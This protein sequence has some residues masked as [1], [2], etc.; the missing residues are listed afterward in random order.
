MDVKEA[1]ALYISRGWEVVPLS[2]G[3]KDCYAPN[4][5]KT[6]F[7]PDDF[8]DN[9]N[10]G[11]K[12][13]NGLVDI[14]LD[15]D[16][17]VA[18]ADTFLPETGAVYGRKSKPKSHR[19]YLSEIEKSAAFLDKT[20][21]LEIRINH[22]SMAPPSIHPNGE[23]VE[24]VANGSATEVDPAL[25]IR[26]VRLLAT[27]AII[28]RHYPGEGMRH[29][30]VM[31]I[32]GMLRQLGIEEED[33]LKCIVAGATLA[34][35]DEI[36]DDRVLIIRKTYSKSEDEPL[37][38]AKTLIEIVED[39]K[40]IVSALKKVWGVGEGKDSRGFRT[41]K[42]GQVI[43]NSLGN[44]LHAFKKLELSC[45]ED[46]F[47]HKIMV[48]DQPFSDAILDRILVDME[49]RFNL[50]A[51]ET[52][53]QRV[54]EDLA[55]RTPRHPVKEYLA[56]LTWDKK[57]RIDKWL[58]TYGGAD[59]TD[60]VRAICPIV[61][62]AAV[63]RIRKPGCKFD[64]MLIL[65]SEQ[66]WNK[67]TALRALCPREEWFT[68]DVSLGL[69]AKETIEQTGGC[70]IIE[71]S[72]LKG[73]KGRGQDR[74]KTFLSRQKDGPVRLA[75][76]K[77]PI[78]VPRQFIIIGTTNTKSG[79]LK[80]MTG[81]RRYWPVLVES[82]NIDKLKRDRDQL[83]AEAAAREAGGESIRLNR[84]LYSEA[85]MEQ[86]ARRGEDPWEEILYAK[87]KDENEVSY[88]QAYDLLSI[89]TERLSRDIQE[90]LHHVMQKLGF[91][92]NRTM[93]RDKKSVKGWR[94]EG[95]E[96]LLPA[97]V[98]KESK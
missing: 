31:P 55:R 96:P 13:I 72:E 1:A 90:R 84:N 38:A 53:T 7:K 45:Y 34:K 68:E 18:L 6:N 74:L 77:L 51:S 39:G 46:V 75:Y 97:A 86:E 73:I 32:A 66:G 2:P 57:K 67:S 42:N 16:E 5:Q 44:L 25:L 92:K 64:E 23:S 28:A 14:D 37:A 29:L 47:N 52:K 59:D 15:C 71:A 4:W 17:T 63:R 33:A 3:K 43:P 24:W 54:L 79:Y 48:N 93:K 87:Y 36:D 49:A 69:S 41:G 8:R 83:W 21:L 65:E 26:S 58:I 35:D 30:F 70:W 78:E 56:G 89:P 12:A 20:T 76:E 22:Q 50:V 10:I 19:L 82:F 9:D 81:N 94:K 61:L 40:E 95:Y 80:D 91:E 11:I 98:R 62:I 27:A 85:E 88:A 60:F